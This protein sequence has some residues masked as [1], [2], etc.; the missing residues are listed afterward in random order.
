[1]LAHIHFLFV[2]AEICNICIIVSHVKKIKILQLNMDQ[3]NQILLD[4]D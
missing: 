4:I 1:M 2:F 3:E